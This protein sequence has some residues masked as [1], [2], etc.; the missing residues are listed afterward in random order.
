MVSSDRHALRTVRPYTRA[1]SPTGNP[2]NRPPSIAAT[3][4]LVPVAERMLNENTAA[5][6]VGAATTGATRTTTLSSPGT[7]ICGAYMWFSHALDFGRPVVK[8]RTQRMI[9]GVHARATPDRSRVSEETAA[10]S[11]GRNTFTNAATHAMHTTPDTTS[12]ST[13]P[14]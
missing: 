12:T 14:K 2:R 9:H 5:S 1:I 4:M 7:W 8:T 13:G 10:A 11:P 6:G 3:R